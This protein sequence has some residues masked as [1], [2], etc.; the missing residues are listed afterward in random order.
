[1]LFANRLRRRVAQCCVPFLLMALSA[2]VAAEQSDWREMHAPRFESVD[3]DRGLLDGPVRAFAEDAEG[4]MWMVADADV[5]RWDGYRFVQAQLYTADGKVSA[6][7]PLLQTIKADSE[8]TLWAGSAQG[9]FRIDRSRPAQPALEPVPLP[10]ELPSVVFIEFPKQRDSS[11]RA[12]F[13]TV[14]SVLV[15]HDDGRVERVDVPNAGPNR[16]HAL[17]VDEGGR[18]WLGTT[19][20]MFE[21]HASKDVSATLKPVVLPTGPSRIA[22]FASGLGGR[23]WVGTATDGLFLRDAQG[24]ITEVSLP[25]EAAAIPRFFS[26]AT[27][28]SGELWAGT[29]GRGLWVLDVEKNRWRKLRHERSRRGSLDNDN[30]WSVFQDSRGLAWVGTSAGAQFIDPGQQRILH[31]P[32]AADVDA[33]DAS[34][35]A[36]VLA[37]S[38]KGLWLGTNAGRIRHLGPSGPGAEEAALPALWA[39]GNDA[40]GAVELL[41]PL[42]GDRWLVGSDWRTELLSLPK[43]SVSTLQPP[44]RDT[45]RFT[46]AAVVWDGAWWFSGPDGVWRLEMKANGEPDAQTAVNVLSPIAGE[47]R[48][49]SLLA[50]PGTLWLGTWSGLARID[51]G[52][53]VPRR[54]PVPALDAHFI[55]RMLADRNGRLWLGTSAGGVFHAPI[56]QADVPT[57]WASISKAEGLPDNSADSLVEDQDGHVWVG[58]SRGLAQIEGRRFSVEAFGPDQGAAAAPYSRGAS[59]LLPGG[60]LAFGGTDAITLVQAQ[61]EP[62]SSR[63]VLPRLV[64][65]AMSA[66]EGEP[67]LLYE[68]LHAETGR[69]RIRVLP[70]VSR[71]SLEF[72]APVYLSAKRLS[73]RFRLK[74][75]EEGWNAVDSDHR[76][77]SFTRLGPGSFV[78]EVQATQL[79]QAWPEDALEVDVEVLPAWHQVLLFRVLAVFAGALVI[80]AGVYWRI[81]WFR[82]RERELERKVAARTADLAEANR[83]LEHK[84][85]IIEEA[86]QTDPLTGLHNRRFLS[87]HIEGD[88]AMALR[89]RFGAVSPSLQRDPTD[90]VFFLIDIDFFKRINDQ[91]GHAAGDA[92]LVETGKRLRALFRESD[93]VVRWGGEEFLVV[94]RGCWRQDAPHVA[95]R[96][97]AA[98]ADLPFKLGTQLELTVTCSVGYAALPLVAAHLHAFGWED[99]INIADEALYEAKSS[100]R[101]AWA[102]FEEGALEI[103]GLALASLRNHTCMARD[104]PGLY[105]RQSRSSLKKNGPG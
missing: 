2:A 23:L 76:I 33:P 32:L 68:A 22:S 66:G 29:F 28:R 60:E 14:G 27:M 91:H 5:W 6:P 73:Y 50:T 105:L 40:P 24:A 47:Q 92:V 72:A 93:H 34:V 87:R 62:A 88:V 36:Q 38:S 15:W 95:E 1:M 94:G 82:A 59:V 65:T 101:N 21:L 89:A 96:I 25:K 37:P 99:T 100:G 104:V 102:G 69:P 67:E 48:V 51:A 49:S 98:M 7:A 83:E 3:P 56:A 81:R 9:V 26:A 20:G 17:H 86:S 103:D 18:V 71:F 74:G 97:C 90:L 52:S 19:Q 63:A 70:E 61:H 80:G 64:L 13:G 12:Y 10:G 11:I 84:N 4:M 55:T 57:A 39:K 42:G 58:T 41:R 35:R 43:Q 8:G 78:L 30:V 77:A 31:L 85:Q 46:S 54:M 44:Q 53:R 79:G 75:W 16:L 45:S